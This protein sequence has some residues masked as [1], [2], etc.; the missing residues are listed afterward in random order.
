LAT[1][2]R[3]TRR[4]KVCLTGG[5]GSGKSSVARLFAERGIEIIDAD[6]LAHDLTRPGGAA[7]PRLVEAFG[8]AALD[9]SGALDRA[10]MR[11]IAFADPAARARLE[12]ILHPLIRAESSRRAA[13]ATSPYLILMIPLLVESGRPQRRCDRVLVVDCPEEEQVRRTMTRSNLSRDEVHAI[14]AAQ[15]S[16]A[17]RL[18]RADDVID[19]GGEPAR[20]EPQVEALHRR[21]LALARR[22]SFATPRP[23]GRVVTRKVIRQNR[24]RVPP[25]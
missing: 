12:S 9:A 15:A 5:I 4:L 14:I 23:R 3:T 19:N 20:L 25:R 7:I 16:R 13:R 2:R 10:R 18:A 21:Y 24:R 8:A 22:A 11:S 6:A 1:G 17:S